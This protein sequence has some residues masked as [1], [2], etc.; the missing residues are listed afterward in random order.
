MFYFVL[1]TLPP[2]L[3]TKLKHIQLLAIANSEHVKTYGM[4]KI[5][6]LI[7]DDI[8]KLV[9][10]CTSID[11]FIAVFIIRRQV[12]VLSL[13]GQYKCNLELFV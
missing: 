3:Q 1:C 4:S 11:Y 2:V 13:V 12:T 5:L 7:F 9:S 6:K 10:T 8:K